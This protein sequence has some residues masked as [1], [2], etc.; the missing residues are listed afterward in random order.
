M[1]GLFGVSSRP[2]N[3]NAEGH[4]RPIA[5]FSATA[6]LQTRHDTNLGL[7][8]DGM[9]LLIAFADT[10]M[11]GYVDHDDMDIV[12]R[13]DIGLGTGCRGRSA[14]FNRC[15]MPREMFAEI[16]SLIARLRAPPAPA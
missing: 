11:A 5:T 3:G 7:K 6:C 15:G 4:Y 13:R 8:P 9:T 12:V 14:C 16:L 10:R 1:K 2:R